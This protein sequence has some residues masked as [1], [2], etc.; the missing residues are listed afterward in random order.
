LFNVKRKKFVKMLMWAGM[1]RNM[2]GECALLAQDAGRPY[3]HVLGDLLNKWRHL[4]TCPWLLNICAVR[5]TIIH[6]NNTAPGRFF[7][8][9]DE[10]DVEAIAGLY[11]AAM[12]GLAK[13][14]RPVIVTTDDPLVQNSFFHWAMEQIKKEPQPAMAAA[15]PDPGLWPKNN[16]HMDGYNFHTMLVDE[17]HGLK[18]YRAGGGQA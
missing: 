3:D 10:W 2:A 14:P 13:K 16:P 17:I 18:A 5:A 1:P 11:E 8:K 4:F 12:A 15:Q 9:I 7:Q 6:G